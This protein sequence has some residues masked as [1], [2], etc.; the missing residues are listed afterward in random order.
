MRKNDFKPIDLLLALVLLTRLPLPHLSKE[1]FARQAA[2]VWAFPLVGAVVGLLSIFAGAVALIW[3]PPLV[4]A[5]IA[6]ATQV[7]VS[8]AMHE[9][10]LADMA[11]GF[12][13]GF[14][15]KR[16]LEIMKDSHIGTYGVLALLF[17]L[18]LR[19]SI[20]A[21]L[22]EAGDIW[23]LM[24]LA[25]LSRAAMPVMMA[26]TPNARGRGL[27][28]SVG[29]PAWPATLVGLLI[30]LGV[31]VL[32]TGDS[33]IWAALVLGPLLLGLRQLAMTKIGGQT[34]DVLGATQQ[35]SEITLGLTLL[36]LL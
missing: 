3:C 18:G 16:R 25:S 27:S 31:G 21:A 12:W 33:A 11:D 23:C 35:L 32:S 19:W 6:L 1:V 29:R 26:S 8:G 10:G 24:A 5:G 4:A 2:A 13:G 36:A 15:P 9:D 7:L 20:L 17:G 28:Q 22:F 34:G 14:D 30:A